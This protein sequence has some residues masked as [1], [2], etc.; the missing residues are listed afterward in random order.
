MKSCWCTLTKKSLISVNFVLLT[1]HG[2][3]DDML[4]AENRLMAEN[5]ASKV[6]RL[7][8]VR[9]TSIYNV[10]KEIKVVILRH[11]NAFGLIHSWRM[12]LT[13]MPRSRITTWMA[14]LVI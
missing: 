9:Q 5:L 8:S 6:S 12:T 14:W 10:I 2:A 4:D 7:K 3:V 1:G 13:K 11:L